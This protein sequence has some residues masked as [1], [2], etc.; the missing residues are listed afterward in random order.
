M[1][2]NGFLKAALKITSVIAGLYV[3]TSSSGFHRKKKWEH[4]LGW[5]YAHRGLHDSRACIPENSMSAFKAA[6]ENGYGIELDVRL[7]ADNQL[8]IMHDENLL[9]MCGV[10]RKVTNMQLRELEGLR[11]AKSNE[12]I[13]LFKDALQLIGGKVPV[14]IEIKADHFE[15]SLICPLVWQ[16]LKDYSGDYCIESFNP[17][18]V[19]WFM[20]HH[21]RVV[22]GQLSCDFFRE[23]MHCDLTL[24]LVT[25]LMTNFLTH[26][27]FISYKYLDTGIPAYQLNKRVF[28]S[29][30]A[31]WTLHSRP[32]YNKFKGRAD[33]II[34]EGFRP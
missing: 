31:L 7:T 30:T 6:V 25:H 15:Q 11:L 10:N 14:I 4:L 5:D 33:V 28:H 3:F 13:P 20:F 18:V 29:M 24:F 2:R 21:P 34:F 32:A 12:S 16:I 23:K 19:Q 8:V 26:P 9:R 1:N 17:F 22:R 27:D